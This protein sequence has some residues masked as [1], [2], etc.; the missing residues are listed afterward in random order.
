MLPV[1]NELT[2]AHVLSGLLA[3]LLLVC[4]TVAAVSTNSA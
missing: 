1:K 2:F 4:S 3:V